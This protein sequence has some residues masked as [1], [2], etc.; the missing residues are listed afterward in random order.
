[1][2]YAKKSKKGNPQMSANAVEALP[3]IKVKE[4]AAPLSVKATLSGAKKG[5]S[6]NIGGNAGMVSAKAP[7]VNDQLKAKDP[8]HSDAYL[9]RLKKR[10][11][12]K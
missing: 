8:D 11:E 12:K 6:A 7:V 4:G 2:L 9:Q 10:M 5:P 3:Q 1:M